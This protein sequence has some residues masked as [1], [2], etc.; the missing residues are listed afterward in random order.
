MKIEMAPVKE[1]NESDL[2]DDSVDESNRMPNIQND[3]H[4]SLLKEKVV[5]TPN[6][7]FLTFLNETVKEDET[8]QLEQAD[9]VEPGDEDG[10]EMEFD[11]KVDEKVKNSKEG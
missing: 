5:S 9:N 1:T 10:F 7:E 3:E 8:D 11:D 6:K 2:D 4:V